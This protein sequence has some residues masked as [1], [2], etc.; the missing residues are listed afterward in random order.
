MAPRNSRL[1]LFALNTAVFISAE[2][3][4]PTSALQLR[5]QTAT[6]NIPQPMEQASL[7]PE[8]SWG[9]RHATQIDSSRAREYSAS[10][11]TC[12]DFFAAPGEVWSALMFY[13]EIAGDRPFLLRRFLPTPIATEGC[14]STI[15]GEVKCRYVGGHLVKRATHI[16]QERNYSFEVVEQNLTLRGIRLLGG[17]YTLHVQSEDCTRVALATHYTS[18][19]CPRWVFGRLEA[20]VCHSFHRYILSAMRSNL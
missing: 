19:N 8:N 3:Q 5:Q 9:V 4:I 16:I 11:T 10:I 12:Q 17:N 18:L 14:K 7:Q 15:G 1:Y 13:E 6:L 2:L 20:A